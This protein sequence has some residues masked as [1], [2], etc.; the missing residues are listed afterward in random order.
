MTVEGANGRPSRAH[1]SQS[2][3]FIGGTWLVR[4][5]RLV[6]RGN[7]TVYWN[8]AAPLNIVNVYTSSPSDPNIWN[9]IKLSCLTITF[10]ILLP[11]R[12]T[13]FCCH[14]T[15]EVCFDWTSAVFLLVHWSM[16]SAPKAKS[17]F[18]E[19]A[20]HAAYSSSLCFTM[21]RSGQP[22]WLRVWGTLLLPLT[23]W[24]HYK[25]FPPSIL[26]I[27]NLLMSAIT[28]KSRKFGT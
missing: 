10:Q 4:A 2:I 27:E 21:L 7:V 20:I 24:S 5:V 1:V 14:V 8:P 12:K 23:A 15:L 28:R 11:Q 17:M 22:H 9:I 3:A 16:T 13:D 18:Q 6:G 19:D 26:A 25:S